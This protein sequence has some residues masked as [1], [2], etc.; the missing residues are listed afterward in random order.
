MSEKSNC[1][2]V[3]YIGYAQTGS[4]SKI[5]LD[6][7]AQESSLKPFFQHPVSETGVDAAIR[8]R[9]DFS[10]ET[11]QVLADQLE[12]KYNALPENEA[13]LANILSLRNNQTFTVTTAHQPNILGGPLYL[14]YKIIHVIRLAKELNET[15]SG[16]HFVPVYYMGSEDADLAELNHIQVE[17]KPYVWETT[18]TG[19]VGRMLVDEKLLALIEELAGQIGVEA[20]GRQ[21]IDLLRNSYQ[22]GAPVQE[23]TLYFIHG[24]FGR[25]GLLVLIPDN[26][27]LKR[28]FEPVILRELQ[29]QSSHKAVEKTAT[30]IAGAGYKVQTHGREINLFYLTEDHRERIEKEGGQY[31]VPAL[32]LTFTTDE[33]IA[34]VK[35]HPERFSGNVVLRGPFQETILPNIIFVGG[36]GELAYWLEMKGVYDEFGIPYPML[37]LRNSFTLVKAKQTVRLKHLGLAAPDFF[38]QEFEILNLLLNKRQAHIGIDHEVEKV[39]ALYRQ[40][41]EKATSADPT[42]EGHAEAIWKAAAKKLKALG[43]KMDR[44]QRQKLSHETDQ[45]HLLKS[46]LFPGNNL[47]ER[48]ENFASFYSLYGP[49]FLDQLLDHS[50]S[51]DAKFGLLYWEA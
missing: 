18:Q 39:E 41:Q 5:A 26:A 16:Q 12:L 49:G 4:F 11:R 47:Q 23:A 38:L 13:A 27:E 22:K 9:A 29:E 15:H 6:Y 32:G 28:I 25:Y 35:M 31:T 43:T 3:H 1:P 8:A 17:G 37:L 40:L 44:A 2:H 24:L 42:L 50:K 36:G 10:D 33:M 14:I 48:T 19:A 7:I 34:E 51:F 20:H 30:A 45:V 46:E 21:L